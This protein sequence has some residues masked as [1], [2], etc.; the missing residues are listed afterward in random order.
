[1]NKGHWIPLSQHFLYTHQWDSSVLLTALHKQYITIMENTE[2]KW[3]ILVKNNGGLIGFKWLYELLNISI[4][5]HYSENY[6]LK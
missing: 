4:F 6:F 2:L 5:L 3:L 1:M